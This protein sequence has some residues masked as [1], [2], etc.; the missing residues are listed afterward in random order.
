MHRQIGTCSC[1]VT[2]LKE[3]PGHELLVISR[4]PYSLSS[5]RAKRTTRLCKE[6]KTGMNA[7]V[8]IFGGN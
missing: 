8:T 4:T 3:V 6:R 7:F 1:S 2:K 5:G